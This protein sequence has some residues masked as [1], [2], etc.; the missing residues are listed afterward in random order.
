MCH[1]NQTGLFNQPKSTFG[2]PTG[3]SGGGLFGAKPAGT[4][5]FG[6]FNTGGIGGFGATSTASPFGANT[7][8][9]SGGGLFGNSQNKTGFALGVTNAFGEYRGAT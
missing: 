5:A 8:S 7:T 4:P 2:A 3:T 9:T 1:Q 6:G